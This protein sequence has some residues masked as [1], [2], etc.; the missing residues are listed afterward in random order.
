MLNNVFF[1]NKKNLKINLGWKENI[2]FT[3]N[4][5]V[6]FNPQET[7]T[8]NFFKERDYPLAIMK[9]VPM[10]GVRHLQTCLVSTQL[11]NNIA[12][13]LFFLNNG[14]YLHRVI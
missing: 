6:N 8:H 10:I 3:P 14:K 1:I 11:E 7:N 4:S 5:G 9:A 13:L 12:L 2:E